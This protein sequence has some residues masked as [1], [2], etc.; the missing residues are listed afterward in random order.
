[1]LWEAWQYYAQDR[2]S[3]LF[4]PAHT[5]AR[6][7]ERG[8]EYLADFEP[9]N[10]AENPLWA[11]LGLSAAEATNDAIRVCEDVLNRH[12]AQPLDSNDAAGLRVVLAVVLGEAGRTN[13]LE[14]FLEASTVRGGN[15]NWVA[16]IR[17]VYL[18]RQP[19]LANL[20]RW[21]PDTTVTGEW[22]RDTLRW[23]VAELAG[24]AETAVRMRAAITAR[25]HARQTN[26]MRFTSAIVFFCVAGVVPLVLA[27]KRGRDWLFRSTPDASLAPWP[28][29]DAL[30]VFMAAQFV[31][32]E[33]A[34]AAGFIPIEIVQYCGTYL[35]LAIPLAVLCAF[36]FPILFQ[37]NGL[38]VRELLGWM[39]WRVVVGGACALFA[40]EFGGS[41][42]ILWLAEAAGA[43]SPWFE[44]LDEY[45]IYGHAWD[46]AAVLANMSVFGPCYE[47]LQMRGLVFGTLRQ[48][49]PLL[50]AAA[51]SAAL[52]AFVHYYSLAGFLSVWWFGFSAALIYERTRSLSACIA[53]HWLTNLVLG[54]QEVAVFG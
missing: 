51:L 27:L 22:T 7:A 9:G 23:R 43:S 5:A 15:T 46:R 12:R 18:W 36:A 17:Q 49:L 24:D 26:A 21:L 30:G 40:L 20:N 32:S 44:S 14:E 33:A 34:A 52:F 13:R 2:L 31:E 42:I 53:G 37:R 38:H 8:M 28:A 41:M 10:R 11:W 45:L 47:E 48:R 29:R 16:L 35:Y 39:D 1:M 4:Y 25:S 6:V 19:G 54:L 50:P 3:R